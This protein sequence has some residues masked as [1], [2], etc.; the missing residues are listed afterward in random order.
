MEKIVIAI[1]GNA[2]TK[3]KEKGSFAEQMSNIN[4]SMKAIIRLIKEGYRVILTHGNGPQVGNILIQNES[5][6]KTV[7]PQPLDICVAKTQGQIGDMI[8]RSL[9]SSLKKE[10]IERDVITVLTHVEVSESD[11]AFKNPT[12]PVG[13]FFTKDEA[14]EMA[15]S[16]GYTMV[17]DSGRGYRRVVPSPMPLNIIEQKTINTLAEN[18]VVIA[19]GGGGIPVCMENDILKGVE[20]VIDK[21]YAS[22]LL[23]SQ[24]NAEQLIILTGV[25]QVAVDFGK[26]EQR[27]L[28]AMTF[29]EAKNYMD[30]GQF[31]RGSMGPKIEAA[32]NYLRNGG[33]RVT[34]TDIDSLHDAARGL[35]GTSITM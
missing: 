20:A 4:D 3:E 5:A 7:P 11:P 33:K 10:H 9:I 23:A 25:K 31:P 32:L 30:S 16:K 13:P 8:S 28:T 35:A 21:D 12:K 22:A 29:D 34:I 17:E 2:I 18:A 26:P 1:G 15:S 19:V 14:E 24:I 27:F 6:K